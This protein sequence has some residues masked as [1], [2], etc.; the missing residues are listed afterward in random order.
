M[1]VVPAVTDPETDPR[2]RIEPCHK[3]VRAF[4]AGQ[5]VADTVSPMLVWEVPYY[6]TYYIPA[7]DVGTGLLT[8]T[9]RTRQSGRLG[10]AELYT[11]RVGGRE[12]V[13]AASRYPA[14]PIEALR[15]L[16]RLDWKAMDA[17]FEED[18]Q[19]YTHARDPYTRVDILPSSRHVRVEAGGVTVAESRRPHLLFETGLPVRYYLP[20]VDVRLDL[21]TPS[22]T[23][24][25][26]PYKG[27]AEY[28]SLRV[29]ETTHE[30][31]VWSYPT[32]LPE[33]ERIAGLMSFYDDKLD[34][35]IDGT[36]L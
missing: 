18:E 27:R 21:L 8:S 17:W 24:T 31:V 3:R 29:G 35:Y 20:K 36:R 10:D 26:C 23:V 6:P 19:V 4:F 34:V 30:D 22:A 28:W 12:A 9:G 14:S 2:V 11:V 15:E 32:P 13:D 16:V 7:S 5:V 33:S 1:A 25:H